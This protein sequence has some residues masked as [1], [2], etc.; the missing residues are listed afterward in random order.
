M[1]SFFIRKIPAVLVT[2]LVLNILSI[3]LSAQNMFRKV[4]DFDG[5]GRADYAITRAAAG[6]KVW[7]IW[8]STAGLKV[9]QFGLSSDRSAAGDYDGDGKTDIAVYR[10]PNTFPPLYT[11][12]VLESQTNTFS[13]KAFTNFGN[14]GSEMM[15]Q[16]YN[17]DGKTDPGVTTGEFVLTRQLS[18]AF[19][20]TDS[21]FTTSIPAS[22]SSI[23]IGDTDGDGRADKAH[24][25]LS[26]NLITI[27]N[28]ETNTTRSLQFGQTN[29]HYQMADFDGD[30]KGDLTIW[31]RA[32][33]DW[34][35][36]KSS[37]NTM[38]TLHWGLPTDFAVPADYDGDG[39]TD[40]AI[41]RP[42]AP[43]YYWVNGSQ[44]GVLIFPWG[45]T[46]DAPVSY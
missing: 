25:T 46:N 4:S 2:G 35:W 1:R 34:L 3:N 32:A 18:V 37:D 22:E 44:Q 42:G 26:G 27:T 19:S 23:R 6:L 21:G 20:G 5:D 14:F 15:H 13:Y 31:R 29:D 12:Y 10:E 28:L 30:A 36:I 24:Y 41:W 38:Q 16:D 40:Q 7:W 45:T 33:G 43:G 8:Q 17:G 11:Y 9:V 39:K